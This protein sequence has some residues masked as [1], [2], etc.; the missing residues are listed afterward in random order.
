MWLLVA[1]S[2]VCNTRCAH[3]AAMHTGTRCAMFHISQH[4][5]HTCAILTRTGKDL[6]EYAGKWLAVC[7]HK[8]LKKCGATL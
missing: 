3:Y 7:A 5:V 6:Y 4:N 8:I 2:V 1:V